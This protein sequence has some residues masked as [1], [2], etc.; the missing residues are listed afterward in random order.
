MPVSRF[1]PVEHVA[2]DERAV[3]L[4]PVGHV[5]VRVARDLEHLEAR[6]V[7]GLVERTV[8]L[9]RRPGSH[10]IDDP[11]HPVVRLARA[12][13]AVLHRRHV[14]LADPQ[15]DAERVADGLARA[16]V[17]GVDVGEGVGGAYPPATL[18]SRL[19]ARW[20]PSRTPAP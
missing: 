18:Q 6:D 13:V 14:G 15:R 16:L 19:R 7:V 20:W 1:I 8:D 12:D 4:T 10:P 9:A 5:A 2:E 11:V 3:R 17:V